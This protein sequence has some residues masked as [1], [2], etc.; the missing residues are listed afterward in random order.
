MGKLPKSPSL[1]SEVTERVV[2]KNIFEQKNLNLSF[3]VIH[4][5][6]CLSY[7]SIGLCF[8]LPRVVKKSSNN[9]PL[10]NVLTMC[11]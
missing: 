2:E 9:L 3:V 7:L 8:H 11:Q 6:S 4:V 1:I 5:G 10:F